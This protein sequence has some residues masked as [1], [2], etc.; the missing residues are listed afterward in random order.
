[1]FVGK[2]SLWSEKGECPEGR[3]NSKLKILYSNRI[4]IM[5]HPLIQ[6]KIEHVTVFLR[7]C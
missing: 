1:M 3:R 4:L 5:N 6:P 2:E 7:L